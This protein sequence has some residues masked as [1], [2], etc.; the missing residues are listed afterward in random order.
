MRLSKRKQLDPKRPIERLTDE[1]ERIKSRIRAK[2][3]Q[4]FRIVK[5][6]FGHLNVRYRGL[7]KKTA[8]LHTLFALANLRMVRRQVAGVRA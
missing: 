2:V 7:T 5:Q 8:Q 6:L 4:P 3:E 1:L